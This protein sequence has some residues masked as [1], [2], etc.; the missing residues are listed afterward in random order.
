MLVLEI[1]YLTGV[2]VAASAYDRASPEWPPHPDRLFSALVCTWAE[3][4][5]DPEERMALEW[6]E[7]LGPPQIAASPAALRDVVEVFV[8]PNDMAVPGRAFGRPLPERKTLSV[9]LAVVPDLRKNRQPRQFPAAIPDDPRVR[10]IW[11]NADPAQTEHHGTALRRLVRAVPY[12]GHSSS[13]VRLAISESNPD[14]PATYEPGTPGSMRLRIPYQGRLEDLAMQY[15]L[16]SEA[17]RAWRPKPAPAVAYKAAE[18]TPAATPR[19]VFGEEWIVLADAG[20]QAPELEG[21]AIVAKTL[22]DAVMTHAN[23]SVPELLSGHAPDATPSRDPHLAIVPLADVGWRY[24]SGRLMGLALILPRSVEHARGSPERRAVLQAIARFSIAEDGVNGRLQLGALGAWLLR[25]E[26]QPEAL[27]LQPWRYL[28][29]A[30]RWATVTP[31]V[32]DRFP[33]DKDGQ[34]SAGIVMQACLN[35]GLPSPVE[36]ELHKHPTFRGAPSAKRH[37]GEPASAGYKVPKN[38]PLAQ[39]PLRHLVLTFETPVRGPVILGA[40]RF[41][42]LGL[43][44][45]LDREAGP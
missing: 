37:R 17:K 18:T 6:L 41:Q 14:G 10:F 38:S 8:P 13:L 32:F 40:G 28:K 12:L 27:S 20:G 5:Q 26:P 4:G 7:A 43:C 42:G 24:S 3:R 15:Q 25:R 39:R 9:Q 2:A 45:P 36:I 23:G 30:R 21:F 11:P 1:E 33:K 34:D 19:S 22:R 44:L 35:I 31:V 29:I 16:A